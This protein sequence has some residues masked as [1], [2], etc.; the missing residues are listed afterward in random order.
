MMHSLT[1]KYLSARKEEIA[2]TRKS[3]RK[4]NDF[5]EIKGARENNLQQCKCQ[6]PFGGA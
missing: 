6:I 5:I 4:W 1:G 3:R 2:D